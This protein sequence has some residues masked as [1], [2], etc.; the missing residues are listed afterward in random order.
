[1]TP[2]QLADA[3]D[4]FSKLP[5]EEQQRLIAAAQAAP[6]S[7]QQAP[8]SPARGWTATQA[9]DAPVSAPAF[10]SGPITPQTAAQPIAALQQQ[11]NASQAAA[12]APTLEDASAKA[13]VGFDTAQGPG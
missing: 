13:R 6:A 8:P 9:N 10:A 1:M 7:P 4:A 5:P 3:A 11:A 2:Q 12:T